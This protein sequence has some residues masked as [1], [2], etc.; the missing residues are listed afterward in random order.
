MNKPRILVALPVTHPEMRF[1]D[2]VLDGTL[3]C[4]GS[5]GSIIRLA[6]FLTEAGLQTC[7]SYGTKGESER[8][9]CVDHAA[10]DSSEFD[11]L[12][13]N[14]THWNNDALTFGNDALPRTILWLQNQTPWSFVHG[15][16]SKGGYRVVCPSLYHANIYRAVPRWQEKVAIVYN[17]ICPIFF[18][19][20]TGNPEK[21]LL[22][23]GA[24][25]PTK[26]FAELMEVWSYLARQG[27][28]LC[29]AIAGSISLHTNS[30]VSLGSLG[31]GDLAFERDHVLPWLKSLPE[32]YRPQFLG[33]L[34]PVELRK[35]ISDSWAVVVNPSWDSPETF[36]VAAVEAQ[37]CD[38][39]VFSV[40]AGALNE[41]V[42]RGDFRSLTA[43]KGAAALG[44]CILRGLGN[45]D[46]VRRNGRLAGEFVRHKFTQQS[47]ADSWLNLL[48]GQGNGLA[49][50]KRWSSAGDIV[51]DVLRWT[52]TGKFVMG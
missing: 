28:P 9:N 38:R 13:V 18:P 34:P 31:V 6:D 15:F 22:F 20:V 32:R 45:Q 21:R 23:V 39:T 30:N 40:A 36:C 41:T 1:L 7:V 14:Q 16:L 5:I 49:Q 35:Q 11:L 27:A 52:G 24:I 37:A 25:T 48:R 4:A 33:A 51:K 50:P 46:A 47:V 44:D 26:G 17:S 10:A 12:I 29:L 42:Y 19:A 8:F 43:H 3:P 2:R